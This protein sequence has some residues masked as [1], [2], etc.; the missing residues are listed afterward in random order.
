METESLETILSIHD[1][2]LCSAEQ[3]IQQSDDQVATSDTHHH[4]S[5]GLSGH[6]LLDL[7]LQVL[8]PG[9]I[10]FGEASGLLDS[11]AD[12]DLWH[13]QTGDTC[14]IVSQEFILESLTGHS[15][16]EGELTQEASA[17][18]WYTPGAGTPMDHVGDLLQLH[19]IH[20]ERGE[21]F[22]LQDLQSELDHGNKVIVGVNAE[23]IWTPHGQSILETL[24]T[25]IGFIPGQPADHAVQVVAIDNSDPSH[26]V[27]VLNDSGTPDGAGERV[28]VSVFEQA[29]STSNHFMVHTE[30]V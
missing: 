13:L 10:H 21:G 6:S 3:P 24:L 7:A 15:F 14:A 27:V 16:S 4:E 12:I 11:T 23:D 28:P 20:I 2:D 29:W 26:P 1:F 17:H 9:A 25:D 22:S 5:I 19:G 18:G 8:G 30:N